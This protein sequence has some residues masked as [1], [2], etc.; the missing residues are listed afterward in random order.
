MDRNRTVAV[1]GAT[2]YIG[3]RLVPELLERGWRVRAV[4]RN[5]EK[6]RCRPYASHP[7]VELAQA[8]VLDL[9]ALTETLKGCHAAFYLVHS[10]L[11]GVKD[12][13]DRDK[14]AALA[15]RDAAAEAGV[16][17]IVYLGGLGDQDGDLSAHLKSRME[18]GEILAA[19]TVPLTW[20]RAAMIMGSGS[21]S[22]EIL[23]YLV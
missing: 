15:M 8:D 20:L 3:G 22:F 18:V 9:N 11:P 4:G 23:R 12:F 2:G 1:L 16:E 10:M 6:L 21:A 14:Q 13:K 7:N 19:G 5:P 17:R